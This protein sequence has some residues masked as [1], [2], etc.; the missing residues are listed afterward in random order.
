MPDLKCLGADVFQILDFFG[1]GDICID[2]MSWIP[3]PKIQNKKCSE[4]LK[5]K[6]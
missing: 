1:F 3:N 5:L 2:F 6:T 4:I